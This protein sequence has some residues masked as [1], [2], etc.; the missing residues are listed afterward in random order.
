MWQRSQE[1]FFELIKRCQEWTQ[2]R[3]RSSFLRAEIASL[4]QTDSMQKE[5]RL[6]CTGAIGLGSALLREHLQR[7]RSSSVD[8]H[9]TDRR[10]HGDSL[11]SSPSH[12]TDRRLSTNLEP[13]SSMEKYMEKYMTR[14]SFWICELNLMGKYTTLLKNMYFNFLKRNMQ[15]T[16]TPNQ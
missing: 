12:S 6:L 2:P 9:P 14:F 15:S 4:S 7:A 10:C 16:D 8:A 1:F 3:I 11:F 5:Q 13:L